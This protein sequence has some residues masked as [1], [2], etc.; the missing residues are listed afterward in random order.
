M[1][2]RVVLQE[3][4]K[5]TPSP[6][7]RARSLSCPSTTS[8]SSSFFCLLGIQQ[9]LVVLPKVHRDLAQECCAT[10][11]LQGLIIGVVLLTRAASNVDDLRIGFMANDITLVRRTLS[12]DDEDSRS[13]E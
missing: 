1:I 11:R 12:Y 5:N 2:R 4:S 7:R 10:E 8:G 13:R 6:C 9:S 3:M